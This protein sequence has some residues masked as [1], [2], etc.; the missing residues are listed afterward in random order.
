MMGVVFDFDGV[1]VD[2]EPIHQAALRRAANE[3]GL[4]FTHEEYLATYIGF[5]D[6]DVLRVLARD[7]GKALS[8]DENQR[9][10]QAKRRHFM[11]EVSEG[12]VRAFPG[13]VELIRAAAARGPI[14][15]CSGARTHE[16]DPILEHLG[17]RSLMATVVS[18]D[19]VAASK[20]APDP[21]TLTA[22]R[23]GQSPRALV[24][25]EDTPAGIES[26]LAAGYAV[27]A[28][29]HSF[30]ADDLTRAN[31]VFPCIARVS[32]DALASLLAD[33]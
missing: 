33:H 9:F 2:S 31:H 16:I 10:H 17:V 13:A 27:A 6:R 20:P 32:I 21:Y 1:I 22:R 23:L 15:V 14:A 29:E 12:R 8:H 19:D 18:A 26:A 24:A 3:V 5:D 30:T 7:R 4:D 11:R 28:V 25:I